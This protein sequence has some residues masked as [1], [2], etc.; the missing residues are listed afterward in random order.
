[1]AVCDAIPFITVDPASGKLVVSEAALDALWSITTDVA[2]CAIVGENRTGKSW[3]MNQL[4]STAAAAPD[5]PRG[6]CASPR[7]PVGNT[8]A[9][10]TQGISLCIRTNAE[11]TNP[12]TSP[13]TTVYLDTAGLSSTTTSQE[14][15]GRIFSLA[16]L[17]SSLLLYNSKGIDSEALGV[18]SV[19]AQLTS[20]IHLDARANGSSSSAAGSSAFPPFVWLLR[21]FALTLVDK[22][23]EALTEREYLERALAPVDRPGASEDE[24]RQNGAKAALRQ[25]FARRE[26]VCLVRPAN[27]EAALRRLDTVSSEALRP[28]FRAQ[29][30]AL[31]AKVT[32]L[33]RPKKM[34]GNPLHGG[35]LASMAQHYVEAM[36]DGRVPSMRSAWQRLVATH[37]R[38]AAEGAAALYSHAM[39]VDVAAAGGRGT[40]LDEVALHALHGRS[41]R[42]AIAEY[43]RRA[44]T[45]DKQGHASSTAESVDRLL[46]SID[47]LFTRTL[48]E[49]RREERAQAAALVAK[50][51]R[52]AFAGSAAA[53]V[54]ERAER[55]ALARKTRTTQKLKQK[56]S[57]TRC[58]SSATEDDDES[59]G[60]SEEDPSAAA[61]RPSFRSAAT[62]ERGGATLAEL[63]R[64]L[65]VWHARGVRAMQ[66]EV[67]LNEQGSAALVEWLSSGK[68]S[69]ALSCGADAVV[70]IVES[71]ERA[72]ARASAALAKDAARARASAAQADDLAARAAHAHD[73]AMRRVQTHR[74]SARK[75]RLVEAE[76][77]A[78]EVAQQHACAAEAAARAAALLAS[79][80]KARLAEAESWAEK[81][82]QQQSRGAEAATRAAVRIATLEIRCEAAMRECA[83]AVEAEEAKRT[84]AL[85]KRERGLKAVNAEAAASVS[86]LRAQLAHAYESAANEKLPVW[87]IVVLVCTASAAAFGIGWALALTLNVVDCGAGGLTARGNGGAITAA[88]TIPK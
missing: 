67:G 56:H 76:S 58:S 74:E 27:E 40:Q 64:T 69:D 24:R 36:N 42:A 71:R 3:I 77:W 16:L 29:L 63:L 2:V 4:A 72:A 46:A 88:T 31:R 17:L 33:L 38:D 47:E 5:S 62:D 80:R 12:G 87:W 34:F 79:E 21:D 11:I 61:A 10:C 82:A 30:A 51:G 52:A 26:L 73:A 68:S 6:A 55:V 41:A 83:D 43:H 60:T 65:T 45:L 19:I 13:L 81:V 7:F 37:E 15:D 9:V 35:Q 57:P 39:R 53:A 49:R 44:R 14:F 86:A 32:T 23:G 85:T 78:G 48:G 75:A 66:R 22:R 54:V 84:D 1:M 20:Q 70:R 8:Q 18:L 25:Y 59:S 50:V 28:K